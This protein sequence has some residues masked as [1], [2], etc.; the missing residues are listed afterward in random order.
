MRRPQVW[1]Y[2]NVAVQTVASERSPIRGIS[3]NVFLLGLVSLCTDTSTE[4][5]YPLI[6]LFLTQVLGAP[7]AIVGVIEGAAEATASLLKG[8]SGWLS[9][10]IGVRR[11]L[12]IFGYGLAAVTKPLL[13]L[14]AGWPLVLGARVLDRF[15]KG[16][17]GTPRDAL[18]ADS[19][20]PELRGRAFGFHRSTDQIGAVAGPLLALP[21]LA[22]FH[23]NYRALFVAAFVPAALGVALLLRVRETGKRRQKQETPPPSFRLRGADP[24]FQRFLAVMMLFAAGNSSDVFLILRAKQLGFSTAHIMAL[25]AAFNF[26]YVVSAYP[27]GHISDRIGRRRVLVAGVAVFALVYL[28]FGLASAPVWIWGLFTTYGLYH[29]LTDGTTR[30]FVVDLVRPEHRATALGMLSTAVG[31]LAFVASAIAGLL[32]QQVGPAAPFFY[33]AATA[34]LSAVLLAALLPRRRTRAA[35]S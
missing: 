20:E 13:A 11:P 10:R 29:G 32:W 33:G 30:A 8:F 12:V 17:R 1:Q 18:I 21:L 35:L 5:I 6:P 3:R 9:D 24:H 14:A 7:M 31:L 27:A 22:A 19:A 15:G 23:Q 2:R 28:G 4:M 25:F 26:V 16:V 34:G